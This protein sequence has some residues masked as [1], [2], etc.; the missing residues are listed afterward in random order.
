[1]VL[2]VVSA[3]V[4]SAAVVVSS[5][6]PQPPAAIARATSAPANGSVRVGMGW[7]KFVP[8]DRF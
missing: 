1:M 5:S 3:A 6:D 8:P 4:A 7:F 2:A